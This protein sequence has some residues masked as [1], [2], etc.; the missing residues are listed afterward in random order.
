MSKHWIVVLGVALVLVVAAQQT[1]LSAAL[2]AVAD[3][4]RSTSFPWTPTSIVTVISAATLAVI[5]TV[6]L[7]Q[8]P[9]RR[10]RVLARRGRSVGEIARRTHLPRDAVRT[11][12]ELRGKPC[13]SA[14]KDLPL[15]EPEA[16]SPV[17]GRHSQDEV[18]PQVTPFRPDADPTGMCLATTPPS[19]VSTHM[20][21][22]V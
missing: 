7:A 13:Y 15:D 16:A 8:R 17:S 20:T 14:R 11:L 18:V 21:Q 5:S 4:V 10:V 1:A 22:D 2:G 9:R 19:H 12:L 3:A 6:H